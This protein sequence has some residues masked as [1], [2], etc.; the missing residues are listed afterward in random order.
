[1]TAFNNKLEFWSGKNGVLRRQSKY[2]TFQLALESE[3]FVGKE[4][5]K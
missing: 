1:M 5:P 2:A 3:R 4:K